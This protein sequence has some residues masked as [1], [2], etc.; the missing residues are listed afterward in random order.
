MKVFKRK[1]Y[2]ELLEWKK[3]DGKYAML[4]EGARRVGKSTLAEEFAK[5]EY[6]SYIL[7]DFS[8]PQVDLKIFDEIYDL[9]RFFMRLQADTKIN[10]KRRKSLIIF[11]EV[12][13][14]PRARQAIKHLVKDNRYDY[15][16]TGSLISI[17]KNIKD[18]LIPSEER[19]MQL[20]PLDYEEFLWAIG[21][22]NFFGLLKEA[23]DRN[24]PIGD[25]TNNKLMKDFRLYMA[26]GGMP[27]AIEAYLNGCNFNEIDSVKKSIIDLYADDFMRI[28]RSG[29]I[30]RMFNG[31]PSQLANN[32]KRFVISRATG[33]KKTYKD[34]E[35]IS[36]LLNSKT[37]LAC[38]NVSD[39]SI[40]LSHTYQIDNFKLYLCDTG[41]FT[42]MLFNDSNNSNDD[43]YSKMLNDKL[44]ANLGYLYEN[45]VAQML[46]ASGYK[47]YYHTWNKKDSTHHYEVDF[48]IRK[49]NKIVPIE[50]KSG[51]IKTHKSIDEFCNKY[52]KYVGDRY[53]FSWR[54]IT[55]FDMLKNIPLYLV[56]FVLQ[57]K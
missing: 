3:L 36:E 38:Y 23:Y 26:I 54:D 57:D 49:H 29:K 14:F 27:Q 52:S 47:L 34:E 16:E 28:D 12:Q 37:V 35:L 1:A 9:D 40:S 50:V 46:T 44:P 4:I 56:P 22:N 11:D 10:L 55:N 42:T 18:I 2:N 45:M 43:I 32:Q 51:N 48:L 6:E 21:D 13:L 39:P 25:G 24:K 17:R 53:L 7:I 15:I 5:N 19:K 41:L 30:S 8:N 20:N 31:I 33:K